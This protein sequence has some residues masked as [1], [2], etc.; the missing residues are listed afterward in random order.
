MEPQSDYLPREP[1]QERGRIKVAKILKAAEQL[2]VEHGPDG[3]SSPQ[4]AEVAKVPVAS[5]YQFFPTRHAILNALKKKHIEILVMRLAPVL[6]ETDCT[7]W[8][9]L[10]GKMVTVAV[11]YLNEDDVARAILL[12][13]PNYP[14]PVDSGTPLLPS[15]SQTVSAFVPPDILKAIAERPDGIS[16]VRVL[17]L[18]T[19]G[20][21]LEGSNR[22]GRI[23]D[24]VAE[25]A[26]I[27]AIC[28][29][30]ARIVPRD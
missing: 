23:T 18:M 15:F 26:R 30:E 24:Q 25:E 1:K 2:V 20:I 4:V 5:V 16:P 9:L 28:Y 27:A 14:G 11:S 13:R 19:S 21:L 6:G 7:N 8:R 29:I 17:L 3:F 10:I 22:H 12:D